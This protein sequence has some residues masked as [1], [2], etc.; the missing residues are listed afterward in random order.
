MCVDKCVLLVDRCVVRVCRWLLLV[1]CLLVVG[2]CLLVVVWRFGVC[3]WWT[4]TVFVRVDCCSFC[5]WFVLYVGC[6]ILCLGLLE[7][8]FLL[9]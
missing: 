7:A 2:W 5:D 6:Y 4:I 1:V 3:C 9:G 8:L